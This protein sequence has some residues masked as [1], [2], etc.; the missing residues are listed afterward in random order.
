MVKRSERQRRADLVARWRMANGDQCRGYR[1]DQHAASD[2]VTL[3]D[4]VFCRSCAGSKSWDDR[5][6]GIQSSIDELRRVVAEL[7]ARLDA[8]DGNETIVP[9]PDDPGLAVFTLD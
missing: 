4:E 9:R 2:F 5:V 8:L 3:G 6:D 7:A 1:T